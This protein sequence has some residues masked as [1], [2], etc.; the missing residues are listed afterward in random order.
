MQRQSFPLMSLTSLPISNIAKS[1]GSRFAKSTDAASRPYWIDKY[2]MTSLF[3]NH[4]L[5]ATIKPEWGLY[6][7]TYTPTLAD[8]IIQDIPSDF[9]VIKPRGSFV[10]RGVIIVAKKNLDSTLKY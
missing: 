4:P 1:M 2:K 10:G 3:N 6:P 9:F 7:K 5:L 8:Q